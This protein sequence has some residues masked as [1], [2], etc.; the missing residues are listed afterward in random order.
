MH[1]LPD[2]GVAGRVPLHVWA[3]EGGTLTFCGQVLTV[4]AVRIR[5]VARLKRIIKSRVGR[6]GHGSG[7]VAEWRSTLPASLAAEITRGIEDLHYL[8]LSLPYFSI[9]AQGLRSASAL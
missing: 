8:P 1:S 4:L 3:S 2:G 5:G 7:T 9:T 6:G